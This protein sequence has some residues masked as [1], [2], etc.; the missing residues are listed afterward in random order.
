MDT[1]LGPEG[2]PWIEVPLYKNY[3]QFDKKAQLQ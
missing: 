1:C 2:V 3:E